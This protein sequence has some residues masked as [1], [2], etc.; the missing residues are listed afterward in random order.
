[1]PARRFV[2]AGV[3]FVEVTH[4]NWDQHVN[5][6]TD[7]KACAEACD[8]PIAGLLRDLKQRGLLKDTL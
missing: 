5:L 6:I 3:R 7:H 1:M 8:L 2:E 4:G